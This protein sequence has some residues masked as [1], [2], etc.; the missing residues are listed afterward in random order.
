MFIKWLAL[1]GVFYP[2]DLS[3]LIRPGT[4]MANYMHYIPE[5]GLTEFIKT[6]SQ[7]GNFCSLCGYPSGRTIQ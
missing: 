4:S 1:H 7:M 6:K 2:T 3:V 5:I